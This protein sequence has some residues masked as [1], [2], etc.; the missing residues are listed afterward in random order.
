MNKDLE[1]DPVLDAQIEAE[2]E[3][4]LAPYL[5][6]YP[7]EVMDEA[8]RLVRFSLRNDPATRQRL[9]MLRADPVVDDSGKVAVGAFR[10]KANGTAKKAGT[11]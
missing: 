10:A 1:E 8:K 9:R 6:V 4:A 7:A 11:K 5:T 2:V 3:R